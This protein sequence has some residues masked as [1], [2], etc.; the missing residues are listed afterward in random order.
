MEAG[1]EQM[2]AEIGGSHKWNAAIRDDQ[3]ETMAGQEEGE[4]ATISD[5]RST[6][7]EFEGKTSSWVEGIQLSVDS[8]HE[9]LYSKI[10]R[11]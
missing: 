8:L 11:T 10:Q 5:I 2:R 9:E 3:G 4:E 6:Q 7:S 1:Q